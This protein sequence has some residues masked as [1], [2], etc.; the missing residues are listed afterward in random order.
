MT[1]EFITWLENQSVA[2]V[3]L[4]YFIWKDNHTLSDFTKAL[5]NLTDAIIELTGKPVK[6]NDKS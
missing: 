1:N 3:M 5:T 4:A 2:L 6:E